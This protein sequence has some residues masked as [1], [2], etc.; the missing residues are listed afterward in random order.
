MNDYRNA[1]RYIL[2]AQ[3]ASDAGK[4]INSVGGVNSINA[5]NRGYKLKDSYILQAIYY[6]CKVKDIQVSKGFD[7]EIGM[8]ILYFDIEGIGQVSFHT[9]RPYHKWKVDEGG[10]WDG[11]KRG[12]VRLICRKLARKYKLTAY[13]KSHK[14]DIM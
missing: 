8:I 6:A 7:H 2:L 4:S 5:S 12:T 3:T 13:Y 1:I 11:S 10:E 14:E 9:H